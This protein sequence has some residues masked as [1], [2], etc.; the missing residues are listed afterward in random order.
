MPTQYIKLHSDWPK[1]WCG[2]FDASIFP[3]LETEGKILAAHLCQHYYSQSP[4]FI[5]VLSIN[6]MNKE[7]WPKF[8]THRIAVE[9]DGKKVGELFCDYDFTNPRDGDFWKVALFMTL[10][11]DKNFIY[12]STQSNVDEGRFDLSYESEHPH[13]EKE[14][15]ELMNGFVKPHSPENR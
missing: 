8:I 14:M 13:V 10:P 15:Q 2:T 3:S 1:T 5:E 7:D 12:I 9:I 6:E 4:T 11:G